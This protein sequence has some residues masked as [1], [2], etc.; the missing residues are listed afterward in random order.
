MPAVKLTYKLQYELDNL[1]EKIQA[2]ES[3]RSDIEQKISYPT[4]YQYNPDE[5][6]ALN[7]E[8]QKTNQLLDEAESRW[9]ELTDLAKAG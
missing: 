2:L 8:F 6:Y 9:L 7:Q 3:R 1:P 4:L 5:F